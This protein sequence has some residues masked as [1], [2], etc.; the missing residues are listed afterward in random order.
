MAAVVAA[1]AVVVVAAE[2]VVAPV[3]VLA[4]V[5]AVTVAA[6]VVVAVVVDEQPAM[7]IMDVKRTRDTRIVANFFII[8]PAFFF[9]KHETLQ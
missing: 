3:S 5:E 7:L 8:I 4:V 9:D 6:A 1:P 2:A